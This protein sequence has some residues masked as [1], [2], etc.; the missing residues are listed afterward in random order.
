[1]ER[2]GGGKKIPQSKLRGRG[3]KVRGQRQWV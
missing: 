3:G 1:M 2:R